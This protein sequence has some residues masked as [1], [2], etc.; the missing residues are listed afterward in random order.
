[1]KMLIYGKHYNKAY[2]IFLNCKLKCL[3]KIQKCTFN[4]LTF[5]IECAIIKSGRVMRFTVCQ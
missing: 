2:R 1:M 5:N 4:V 3:I